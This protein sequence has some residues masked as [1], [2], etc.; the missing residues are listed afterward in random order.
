MKYR[1]HELEVVR[2]RNKEP[3]LKPGDIVHCKRRGTYEILEIDW[4]YG[5]ILVHTRS[6][7]PTHPQYQKFWCYVEN[8]KLAGGIYN[9]VKR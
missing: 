1:R 3:R 6:K 4:N 9:C 2:I 5:Y 7:Y 8:V